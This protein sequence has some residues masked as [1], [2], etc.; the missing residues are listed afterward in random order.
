LSIVEQKAKTAQG[1]ILSKQLEAAWKGD[2]LPE[3][4]SAEIRWD[5]QKF[6]D[7]SS[8]FI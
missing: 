2:Y 5:D 7:D 1:G 3:V 6:L 4:L 8:I